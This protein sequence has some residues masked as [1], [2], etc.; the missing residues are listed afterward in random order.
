MLF[1]SIS[2]EAG[3]SQLKS[4][5]FH[6]NGNSDC[7]APLLQL[8]LDKIE[9]DKAENVHLGVAYGQI[10]VYNDIKLTKLIYS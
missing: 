3:P 5:M 7:L 1:L 2:N 9:Q 8:L 4:G 10:K 6:A